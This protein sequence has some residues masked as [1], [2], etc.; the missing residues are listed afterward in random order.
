MARTK[1]KLKPLG[2]TVPQTVRWSR[3]G[4]VRERAR[5]ADQKQEV[6]SNVCFERLTCLLE[7]CL[8]FFEWVNMFKMLFS[9]LNG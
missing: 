4:H 8:L 5:F 7:G 2:G 6:M 1:F 3:G 9:V